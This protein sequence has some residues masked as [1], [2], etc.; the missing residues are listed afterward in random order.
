[1]GSTWSGRNLGSS[2]AGSRGRDAHGA[3]E[4]ARANAVFATLTFRLPPAVQV[5]AGSRLRGQRYRKTSYEQGP[6]GRSYGPLA[7]G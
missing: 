1:M 4:S 2:L 3:K 5:R 6:E 7:Q